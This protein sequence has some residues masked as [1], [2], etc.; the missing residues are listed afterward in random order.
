MDN[1][2]THHFY[3][4]PKCKCNSMRIEGLR[5]DNCNFYTNSYN[6]K[7]SL[8]DFIENEINKARQDEQKRVFDIF[9]KRLHWF[10]KITIFKNGKPIYYD[11]N[12]DVIEEVFKKLKEDE[13]K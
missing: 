3:K 12:K 5:C 4:C 6:I 7:P 10:E 2:N 11:I 13:K 9:C 1:N 8:R